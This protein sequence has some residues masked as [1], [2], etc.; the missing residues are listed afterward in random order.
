MDT[1]DKIRW[2]TD[3]KNGLGVPMTVIGAYCGLHPSTVRLHLE[4]NKPKENTLKKYEAG[5]E[6]IIRDIKEYLLKEEEV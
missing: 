3:K 5:L 1:F 4:N 6:N 2:L